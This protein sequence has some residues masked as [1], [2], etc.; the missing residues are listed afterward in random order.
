MTR[1]LPPFALVLSLCVWATASPA[2]TGH[3][4]PDARALEIGQPAGAPASAAVEAPVV[5]ARCGPR[6]Q[7]QRRAIRRHYYGRPHYR[8][9]R[10]HYPYRPYRH[11]DRGGRA[12]AA[13]VGGVIGLG[14]GAAIANSRP[15]Y[16]GE[17]YA[18]HFREPGR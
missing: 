18:P 11:R 13:I 12:A 2:A 14:I 4:A 3:L 1:T 9:H 10:P 7:A 8:P 17:D 15:R 5:L 16:Y 6:C